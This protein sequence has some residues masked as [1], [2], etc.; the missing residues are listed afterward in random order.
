MMPMDRKNEKRQSFK[1][2]ANK[3]VNRVLKDLRLIGNLSN[4]QNYTYT[5]SDAKLILG[6]IEKEINLVKSRFNVA[7][8]KKRS[9]KI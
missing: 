8:S 5:D 9:I 1:R 6:A 7:L 4:T 3:R 2:L